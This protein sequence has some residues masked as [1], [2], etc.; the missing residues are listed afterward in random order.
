M[1]PAVDFGP[2]AGTR[3]RL[4][5]AGLIAVGVIALA[6]VLVAALV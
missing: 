3:T 6:A 2:A 5:V 1:D 4:A